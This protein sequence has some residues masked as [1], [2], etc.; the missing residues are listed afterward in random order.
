[1]G[2]IKLLRSGFTRTITIYRSVFAEHAQVY[3][4]QKNHMDLKNFAQLRLPDRN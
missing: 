2:L 1:M 3:K 4:Y